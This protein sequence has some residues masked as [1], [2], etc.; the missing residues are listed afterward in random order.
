MN[1]RALH[2]I[3]GLSL[4]SLVAASG[5]Q[6]YDFVFQP[7][8]NR[9]GLHLRFAVEQPSKADILFVVDN[10]GSMREHQIALQNSIGE[11]LQTLAP[12][13][14]SYRIGITSTDVY[15]S[16]V[17]C[18]GLP[19]S[20]D[21]ALGGIGMGDCAR[22][23]STDGSPI[24]RLLMPH[25]GTRGRL[26]AAYDPAVFDVTAYQTL[27]TQAEQDAFNALVKPA[28]PARP[29]AGARSVIDRDQ[30]QTE[31][32]AA[33]KCD[34][35]TCTKGD[36]CFE[37]CA[38]DVASALVTAYFR[39]NIAGLGT[40]GSGYESGLLGGAWAVGIDPTQA[41]G[42]D[43]RN[44][45]VAI[46]YGY[47]LT[48]PSKPNSIVVTQNGSPVSVPWMRDE[49]LLAIMFVSD[50]QDCSMP[51]TL[52]DQRIRI[53]DQ[54]HQPPS[55]MCYMVKQGVPLQFYSTNMLTRLAV[56]K[57]GSTS[58]L[59]VGFI[60]GVKKTGPVGREDRR[61]VASDCVSTL[62]LPAEPPS[63]ECTCF[64]TAPAAEYNSWCQFTQQTGVPQPGDPTHHDCDAEAGSRYVDFTSA[65]PRRTFESICD[66]GTGVGTGYGAALVRFAQIATVACFDLATSLEPARHDPN[67]IV[68]RR[69]TKA[70]ADAGTAPQDLD[71]V[72]CDGVSQGWCWQEAKDDEPPRI[73][74]VGFNRLIG[75]VYDIFVLTEDFLDFTH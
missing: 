11:L 45:D 44:D 36:T 25:D 12:Q 19:V 73:C 71:R 68:V 37:T 69:S 60:G 53:E 46:N 65:F 38:S 64:A 75:D 14:T 40:D 17:D 41:S 35:D 9:L 29:E 49:A 2:V 39:S 23:N 20:F 21:P 50:E 72:D 30:I 10:S 74:L 27:D 4:V 47:H 63:T 28:D 58:R 3:A 55:S 31:A 67:N 32:C 16:Q 7:D 6:S 59:A 26:I 62:K 18:Q 43:P 51:T 33:C 70:D 61:G 1:C 5:C 42:D 24:V 13:D 57:K 8:S 54:A 48:A 15:G 52:Y 66:A 34:K 56:K 22:F